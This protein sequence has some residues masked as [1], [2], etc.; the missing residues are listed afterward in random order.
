MHSS[1]LMWILAVAILLAH[2]PVW[3]HDSGAVYVEGGWVPRGNVHTGVISAGY[4]FPVKVPGIGGS[5]STHGEVF[6]SAWRSRHQGR[7]RDYLQVGVIA[8]LR[9]RFAGGQ[10]PWFADVGGGMA[11][12]N[13]I[14]RPRDREFSTAFQFTQVFGL[15]FTAQAHEL[16]VRMQHVSNA[17]IRKPNPGENLIRLRYSYQF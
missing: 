9:C 15:G 10:S 3:A 1:R 5:L 6:G 8:T 12:F 17:G 14:Y 7:H 4:F 2:S 13:H 11:V 16:A